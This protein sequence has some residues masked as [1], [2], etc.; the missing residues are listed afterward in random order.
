MQSEE[1]MALKTALEGAVE[2]CGG[3]DAAAVAEALALMAKEIKTATSSMTSV[4]KPLKFLNPH[5]DTLV[6]TF[7]GMDAGANKVLLADILAALAM[8]RTI[9]GKRELLRYK[10]LGDRKVLAEWGH[11]FVRSLAGEIGEVSST[12]CN[13]TRFAH[14]HTHT[15]LK[16]FISC[17]FD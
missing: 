7:E 17:L 3:S 10:M 11:E 2:A 13:R 9:N 1:D 15:P 14:T 5:F 4:P 8:T 16:P 12:I 6:S